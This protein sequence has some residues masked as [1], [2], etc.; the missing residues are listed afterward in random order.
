MENRKTWKMVENWSY[1]LDHTFKKA[2]NSDWGQPFSNSKDLSTKQVT[3]SCVLRV[4]RFPEMMFFKSVQVEMR[5]ATCLLNAE[6]GETNQML[7][8][9][10][11]AGTPHYQEPIPP[12]MAADEFSH[13]FPT[14]NACQH[15]GPCARLPSCVW[16]RSPQD[17]KKSHCWID[18][19]WD[20]VPPPR[21]S[22]K[23]FFPLKQFKNPKDSALHIFRKE[24]PSLKMAFLNSSCLIFC[25][26]DTWPWRRVVTH[27]QPNVV[28]PFLGWF[29]WCFTGCHCL[30]SFPTLGCPGPNPV[31]LRLTLGW[32]QPA[33]VKWWKRKAKA[34]PSVSHWV[35]FVVLVTCTVPVKETH[36]WLA[37]LDSLGCG[38][39][40]GHFEAA[41]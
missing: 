15:D 7:P 28:G 26:K 24:M 10:K 17:S 12:P 3:S 33:W 39:S 38:N 8:F 11:V 25:S 6:I 31:P 34:R 18:S 32:S 22:R 35:I 4:M 13:K 16:L 29:P 21:Q 40:N 5:L 19:N 14:P 41:F 36:S 1:K 20:Q 37:F 30:S 2:W 27:W 23:V 9:I